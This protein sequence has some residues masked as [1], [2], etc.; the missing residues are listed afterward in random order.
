MVSGTELYER[1]M[2]QVCLLQGARSRRI[3]YPDGTVHALDVHGGGELPAVV[4][5][6]GF[7]ASAATQYTP[8]L[9]GLRAKVR[10]VVMPDLPGHGS[11]TIPERLE[12]NVI[13]HGVNI[14]LDELLSEPAVIF[15]TSLA[16]GFAVRY[17][18]HSPERVRGL[19]LC[20]PSGAPIGE[21]ELD[22]LYRLFRIRSHRGALAFVDRLFPKR[23]PALR[24]A[25]AWG[26]RQQF[27]RPH[28]VEWLER[29]SA[30]DFLEPDELRRLRMPVC[31]LWGKDDMILPR[32]HFEF[33]RQHL[34]THAEI[35][36]PSF[37][38]APFLERAGEV[39]ELLLRFVTR[40]ANGTHVE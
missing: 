18:L 16:G 4:L 9:R 40:V 28:L 30:A 13:Q 26:V 19:M 6:H 5:L 37:G 15:A 7:S 22:D 38:H 2:R 12:G 11:S 32:A 24:Q 1:L 20:S 3:R 36:T 8:M 33:F 21:S 34:P 27:N 29:L 39:T 23:K 31:L 25:Y 35:E 17:A 10:R 14:A